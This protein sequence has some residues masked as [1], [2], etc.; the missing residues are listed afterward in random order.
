MRAVGIKMFSV[1]SNTL[2]SS[3]IVVHQIYYFLVCNG[4]LHTALINGIQKCLTYIWT[5]SAPFVRAVTII[6]SHCTP[7]IVL[8]ASVT[9]FTV[10]ISWS[11]T[12][13]TCD[14]DDGLYIAIYRH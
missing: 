8:A 7:N 2:Q 3:Y 9:H 1:R 11:H 10:V 12:M 5:C 13:F 6:C 14:A 4:Q